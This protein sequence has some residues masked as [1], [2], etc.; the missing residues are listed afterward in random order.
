ML[1]VITGPM[2]SGKTS[3]LLALA[4]AHQIAGKQVRLFKPSNDS[5][6]GNDIK[7]HFGDAL[8][9]MTIPLDMAGVQKHFLDVDVLCFDEVQFFQPSSLGKIIDQC[10][11][12]DRKEIIV[13]GL[14]QD[15]NGKPFGEMPR[16]L[17][18][19]D[20]IIHLTAVCTECGEVGV[21]T[22]TYRKD[23]H[24]QEQVIVGG[25]EL[26][27]ARCLKHWRYED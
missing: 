6:Y 3:R 19:A 15:F 8:K 5:R 26:Y 27:E 9:C 18:T 10:V 1:T 11:Y 21:A 16:L 13:A 24:N 22:R 14:S 17:A 25:S 12:S 2:Y 23:K 4:R 20:R 7:T